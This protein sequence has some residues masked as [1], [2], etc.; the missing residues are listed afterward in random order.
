VTIEIY[1]N[2]EISVE[3]SYCVEG[4]DHQFKGNGDL[5]KARLK[6]NGVLMNRSLID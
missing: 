3:Y 4:N 5:P 6:K 2:K 1:G